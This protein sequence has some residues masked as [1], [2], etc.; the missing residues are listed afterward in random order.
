[1]LVNGLLSTVYGLLAVTQGRQVSAA[2]APYVSVNAPVVALTHAR[3]VDG[4][5]T[6][7]REDQTVVVSGPQITAV[8][9]TASTALPAGAQV[10]DLTGHTVI[11]GLVQLH[12][13]TYFGGVKQMTEMSTT[14]PLLYLAMGITTAMTA[15]SQFPYPELNM[16]RM[17]DAG[18]LPGPRFR[19]TGPYLNGGPPRNGNARILQS[20]EEARRVIDYWVSEGATWFKFQGTVSREI[21]GAAILEAHKLGAKVTGHLCSVTFTEAASLGID[22]LQHGFITNSDYVPNKKPDVCPPENMRVQ[23]EVDVS[24]PQVQQSIR[25]I[26]AD[27]AAV[28]STLA[29]YETFVA[30]RAKLD[31]RAMEFLDPDVRKEVEQNHANIAKGGLTVPPRLIKKMMQWERD[32]VMAG[33]LLGSGSDP[34]GTGFLPGW[35]N[36]RNYEL[37]VEA[38]FSPEQSIQIMTSNGARI[39]GEDGARGTIATGKVADLVVIRGNPVGTPSDIYEVVTVFKDGIGYD[40]MKLREAAK[41]KVG[42]S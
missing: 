25:Q 34:W 26:V 19:I 29:V 18:L 32:F 39:L 21:L 5:G 6:P 12:E 13:H 24:S 9:P 41:G 40:S 35:G 16:K 33:G 17:V 22:L 1:M 36:L 11:P 14:G 2:I 30:E 8:G 20:P 4:T 10:I 3:L 23:A 37:L 31:P 28:A 38:G 15:G 7:A 27:K 42:S